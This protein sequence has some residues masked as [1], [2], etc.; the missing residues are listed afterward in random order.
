MYLT[1]NIIHR[2]LRI[3]RGETF[4]VT[5]C[6]TIFPI[7]SPGALECAQGLHR[8]AFLGDDTH[9]GQLLAAGALPNQRDNR[10]W[11]PLHCAVVG[12]HTPAAGLLLGG[13]ADPNARGQFDLGP[14]HWAALEGRSDM[15]ALLLSRGAR[16]DSIDL[17]GETP[18][19]LAANA[20]TVEALLEGGADLNAV[21]ERGM[22]PLHTARNA[23]CGRAL[24]QRGADLRIRDHARRTP[25]QLLTIPVIE[26]RLSFMTSQPGARLRGETAVFDLSARNVSDSQL[27]ELS[28]SASS[29][30]C[31]AN[32]QPLSITLAP[33]QRTR[34]RFAL[35]RTTS[36]GEGQHPFEVVVTSAGQTIGRF[37]IPVVTVR[38]E[39]LEDRGIIRV[40]KTSL[41]PTPTR[42][43]QLAFVAAP[44]LVVGLWLLHRHRARRAAAM[45]Q[46]PTTL[47]RSG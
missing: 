12:G 38:T 37:E 30:A 17:Y 10:D 27:P 4:V 34:F 47:D 13:G 22:T 42:W 14:L 2:A 11:T 29:P 16:V 5:L 20:R 31:T 26:P 8:A 35:T 19:H 46:A 6:A 1:A 39:T 41:R 28:L 23:E 33:G 40:A 21:D 15:V 3:A 7:Y 18:L 32:S 25:M 45:T 44:L 9:L 36:V 43:S 24:L